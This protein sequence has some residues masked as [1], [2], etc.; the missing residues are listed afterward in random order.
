MPTQEHELGCGAI[1]AI[2]VI[3]LV[4]GQW[5]TRYLDIQEKSKTCVCEPK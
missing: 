5:I 1:I 3:L 2:T 4:V